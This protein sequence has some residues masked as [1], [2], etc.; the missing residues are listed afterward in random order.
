MRLDRAATRSLAIEY[1]PHGTRANAV[2]PGVIRTATDDP[3]AY[4]GPAQPRSGNAVDA[5]TSRA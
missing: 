4:D 5:V 2:S 1:A 3:A